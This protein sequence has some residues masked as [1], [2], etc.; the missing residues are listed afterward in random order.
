MKMSKESRK[1]LESKGVVGERHITGFPNMN[2]V[3]VSRNCRAKISCN[4][5]ILNR[6]D[7]KIRIVSTAQVLLANHPP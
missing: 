6:T 1:C 3:D 2:S 7:E 4:Y 5:S